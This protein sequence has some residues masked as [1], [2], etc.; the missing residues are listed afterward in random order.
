[1]SESARP[2]RT[3]RSFV[4]R[5][6]RITAAQTRA[7]D[8]L[9]PRYG[10]PAGDSPLDLATLFGR[11]APVHLEIGFGNGEAL[12][13]MAIAH[14]ENNYLGIEVHRPGVGMLLRTLEASNATNVRVV[15]A[16]AREV[17]EKRI[18][19]ASLSAIYIF[20]PDPWPKKRHH[21]RRLVQ[22]EFVALVLRK[23]RVGGAVH[24]ATDWEDYAQQMLSVLS[25][26][27]G[28][29]NV[30]ATGAYESRP[31]ARTVTRF[32]RRGRRLGHAVHD[33]VFL[34]VR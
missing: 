25:S 6:G 4:R 17:I 14:P 30:A 29:E 12:A 24:L 13:A 23:L 15:C 28:L 32:E 1:M 33:L 26:V 20:F 21:K 19:D 31:P 22:K 18:P 34:R 8:Q 7:L 16:D 3:I 11:P 27:E 10:V 2:L 9:L 5:E